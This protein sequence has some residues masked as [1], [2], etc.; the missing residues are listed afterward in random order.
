MNDIDAT[1]RVLSVR[2]V[3]GD[4]AH[5][6]I[7]L[8]AAPSARWRLSFNANLPQNCSCFLAGSASEL[9]SASRKVASSL[10]V[11]SRPLGDS[12]LTCKKDCP[13]VHRQRVV[14]PF[15][16]SWLERSDGRLSI[17]EE[18]VSTMLSAPVPRCTPTQFTRAKQAQ[19]RVVLS[20]AN[21]HP[22]NTANRSVISASPRRLSSDASHLACRA[23]SA[24]AT[25]AIAQK[26]AHGG[27]RP[28][29]G[30]RRLR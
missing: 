15:R 27:S 5:C 19:S 16:N 11:L 17:R 12:V 18:R 9:I 8:H 10:H 7:I 3:S 2:R 22:S 24:F 1:A 20:A 26:K 21:L 13:I 30:V 29:A 14:T 23:S 25:G 6:T 28:V 4:A